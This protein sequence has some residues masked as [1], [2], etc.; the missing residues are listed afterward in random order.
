M[1][2]WALALP[3][4]QYVSDSLFLHIL[5]INFILIIMLFFH[6]QDTF[7]YSLVYD[8]QQ[9]TL[10][11]DKGEIRVGNRYQTDIQP[12]LLEGKKRSG[13]SCSKHS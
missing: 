2:L 11:A 4:V 13:P 6:L 10:L 8:P 1:T 12:L 5:K 9:K 3:V 7:F